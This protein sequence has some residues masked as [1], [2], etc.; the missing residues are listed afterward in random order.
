MHIDGGRNVEEILDLLHELGEPDDATECPAF[1]AKFNRI[2]RFAGGPQR[3]DKAFAETYRHHTPGSVQKED[4]DSFSTIW[5]GNDADLDPSAVP[6][7]RKI[8]DTIA[9]QRGAVVELER[10]IAV[11]DTDGRWQEADPPRSR[12]RACSRRPSFVRSSA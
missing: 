3:D 10:V 4:F 8:L 11:L 6:A 12:T 2:S 5:L 9:E 7:L 1:P